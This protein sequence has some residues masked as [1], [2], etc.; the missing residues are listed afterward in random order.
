MLNK[1][2]TVPAMSNIGSSIK[3]FSNYEVYHFDT[4]GEF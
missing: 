1:V 3:K 2:K 4:L